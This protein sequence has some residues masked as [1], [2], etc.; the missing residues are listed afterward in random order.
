MAAYDSRALYFYFQVK[1]ATVVKSSSLCATQDKVWRADAPV[2]FLDP[3]PWNPDT[4]VY[5]SY[6][7]ADASGLIF[8]TSPK[9]IQI[10]K[11]LDDDDARAPYF[12]NRATGDKFQIPTLLPTGVRASVLR[13]DKD[14]TRVAVEM[15][16]PFWGGSSS[17]FQPGKSMFISWGFN[18]YPSSLWQN[19]DG[20]PLAYS[21]AKDTLSYEDA[22]TKPPGWRSGD[23]IHYDPLRS[24]DGWGQFNLE[25]MTV[26]DPSNCRFE[27]PDSWD[28][29][30]WHK[31]GC[32]ISLPTGLSKSGAASL[33]RANAAPAQAPRDVRGRVAEARTPLLIF[34]WAG[35]P[36]R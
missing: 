8:G 33:R 26:I 7:S 17:A 5:R 10:A 3:S 14:S 13:Y 18:M 20:F 6:F 23:S 36:G 11:P 35:E 32:G 12:R 27:D 28:V 29:I 16:I 15:K 30:E 2:L 22:A 31:S 4:A 9:S 1:T 25:S 21:W 19:C 34:P 24:W